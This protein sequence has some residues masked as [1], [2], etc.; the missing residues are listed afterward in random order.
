[1]ATSKSDK[2][3]I[4]GIN[5]MAL[6]CSDMQQTVDFYAGVLGLPMVRAAEL[7]DGGQ[8]FFFQISDHS[9]I[10][11]YYF[12]QAPEA[13]PD[14][15][16]SVWSGVDP[17]TGQQRRP[18]A[19]RSGP[20]AQGAMHHV[21]FDIPLDQQEMYKERLRAAG[22]PCTEVNHHILYGKDGKQASK[23]G[24]VPT[25]AEAIDEF[26]NSIYFAGPDGVTLE[27]A[28]WKRPLV[29]D[30]VKHV[31]ARAVQVTAQP[32][33]REQAAEARS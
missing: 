11:F 16:H 23:P 21:A 27:F 32:V 20:P 24:D 18:A 26:V 22:V 10:S 30:D 17:A 13:D 7:P 33:R 15:T 8:Q 2:F 31:P 14:L 12:P 5:H 3:E 19:G 29:P 6:V 1:M 28:G 25:D 9:G 4:R